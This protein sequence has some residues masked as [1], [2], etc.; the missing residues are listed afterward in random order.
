M[1]EES[2]NRILVINCGSSSLKYEVWQMPQRVSL[3]R[4]L[5]ERIGELRER[6]HRRRPRGTARGRSRCPIT[7]RP[8]SWSARPS[9]TPSRGPSAAWRRS[10]ESG[11]GSCTAGSSTRLRDHRR[12]RR[13]GHREERRA[14]PAAQPAEPHRHPRGAGGAARREAG[15]GLRYGVPPDHAARRLPLRP[16][17]RAVREVQDPPLRLSRHEPPLRRL[18]RHGAAEALPR[19]H[20]HHHLPPGQRRIGHRDRARQVHRYLHGLHAPGRAH[21]GHAQRRHRPRHRRLPREARLHLRGG[22]RPPQQEERPPGA[23]G[24]LQ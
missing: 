15:G 22:Q 4:G 18:P 12:G 17:L 16:A 24:H 11:I 20:E 14:R 8:W 21:D 7:R 1:Q 9:R 13:G 10:P 3:G 2:D 19:E 6:S 23:L 5:V